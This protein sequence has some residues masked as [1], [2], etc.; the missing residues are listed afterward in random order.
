MY[1]AMYCT[2][3]LAVAYTGLLGEIGS[4]SVDNLLSTQSVLSLNER[5]FCLI[6]GVVHRVPIQVLILY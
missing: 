3:V 4:L 5:D 6:G 2:C 1:V